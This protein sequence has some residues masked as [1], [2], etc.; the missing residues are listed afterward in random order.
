VFENNPRAIAFYR[1]N[2]FTP[3]G[4][5]HVFGPRLGNQPEIRMVR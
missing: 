1:R 4:T 2:G 5:R 3:N